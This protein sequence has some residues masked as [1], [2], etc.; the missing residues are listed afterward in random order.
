VSQGRVWQ[1]HLM[2]LKKHFFIGIG[3]A[4]CALIVRMGSAQPRELGFLARGLSPETKSR[5]KNKANENQTR[6]F[7]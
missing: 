1:N 2:N 7:R 3:Y 5:N 6:G 4:K